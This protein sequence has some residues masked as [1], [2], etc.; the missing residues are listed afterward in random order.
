MVIIWT[1]TMPSSSLYAARIPRKK[2]VSAGT[3]KRRFAA[4]LRK[5]R[6]HIY[7]RIK[8]K[9]KRVQRL[10]DYYKK[11][12]D[13]YLCSSN[14]RSFEVGIWKQKLS[15]TQNDVLKYINDEKKPRE[16]AVDT[17]V[18]TQLNEDCIIRMILHSPWGNHPRKIIIEDYLSPSAITNLWV[19]T[20]AFQNVLTVLY[21]R[22]QYHS[23]A[24][25]YAT[26]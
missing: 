11:Q 4:K 15:T 21:K 17:C 24:H 23:S 6:W 13:L 16:I 1:P 25:V 19:V 8:F 3:K 2:N 9:K 26:K 18:K 14:L 12:V 5:L 7:Q 22:S 20:T 10:F